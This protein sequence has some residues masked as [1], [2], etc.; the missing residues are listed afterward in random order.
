MRIVV[1]NSGYE[2]LNLGDVAMLQVAVRRLRALWPGA[3]IFVPTVSPD[4]LARYCPET[5]PLDPWG[6][7]L[8]LAEG[9]VFGRLPMRISRKARPHLAKLERY[10]RRRWAKTLRGRVARQ[11]RARG[12]DQLAMDAYL[13]AVLNADLVLGSGGGYLTDAFFEHALFA[14]ETLVLGQTV[15]SVTA[16]LGQ[17]IGPMTQQRLLR[18]ARRILPAVDLISLRENRAGADLLRSLGVDANRVVTTGDDAIEAALACDPHQAGRHSPSGATQGGT[19]IGVNLRT[20]WYAGVPDESVRV[21]RDCLGAASERYGSSLVPLPVS[22]HGDG[23][24]A[25]AIAQLLQG[26]DRVLSAESPVETPADLI[27][28]I[29][30]CRIVVTGSYHAGVF[31]MA[32][33]IPTVALVRSAYYLDKF[34][35]LADQ[36]G[37]SEPGQPGCELVM[38][39]AN[40]LSERLESAIARAWRA[41]DSIA[42]ALRDAARRQVGQSQAAYQRLGEICAR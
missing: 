26:L 10:V 34:A 23:E 36:F 19:G 33:G 21:A 15:G 9:N 18:P 22:R 5:I 29:K 32:Q 38:L 2:L 28:T 20:A 4:L 40:D 17:G 30:L 14:M 6:R 39:D 31:A 16:L 1:E 12:S 25:R 8:W 3:E 42:P 24:D 37:V 41:A 11:V 35:G 7:T 27:R 13:D